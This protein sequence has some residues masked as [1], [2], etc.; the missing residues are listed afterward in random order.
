MKGKVATK[1]L[2]NLVLVC[3]AC[4]CGVK[5]RWLL[6]RRAL[7]QPTRRKKK[8]SE[9]FL[10][11]LRTRRKIFLAGGDSL[12]SWGPFVESLKVSQMML[13]KAGGKVMPN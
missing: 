11:V 3:F 13:W 8:N 9:G 6:Q 1:N 10:V 2:K 5:S 12:L 7:L 4:C